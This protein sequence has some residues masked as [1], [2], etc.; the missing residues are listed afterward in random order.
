[1]QSLGK[2]GVGDKDLVMRYPDPT[3]HKTATD[4]LIE[5]GGII[6]DDHE[7]LN[8]DDEHETLKYVI[9]FACVP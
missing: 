6:V 9:L 5:W 4:F 2:Y 7:R 3:I 1:M 8:E